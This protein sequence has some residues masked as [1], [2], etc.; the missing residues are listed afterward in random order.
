MSYPL[1]RATRGSGFHSQ[2]LAGENLGSKKLVYLTANGTW[3]LADSEVVMIN[4]GLG[5]TKERI[6]SGMVGSIHRYGYIGRNDWVFITGKAIYASDVLGEL[7]QTMLRIED[8]PIG[9]A[10]SRR[11]I[12]FNP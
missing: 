10:E 4:P 3:K 7:T 11:L 6:K 8:K 5:I 9:H 2:G 12:F 1:T